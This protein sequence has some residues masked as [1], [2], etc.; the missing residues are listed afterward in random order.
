MLLPQQMHHRKPRGMESFKPLRPAIGEPVP[1]AILGPNVILVAG[2]RPNPSL[3]PA[4]VGASAD[5]GCLG[6]VAETAAAAPHACATLASAPTAAAPDAVATE[7]LGGVATAELSAAPALSASCLRADPLA[8]GEG[9][10]G[11]PSSSTCAA[12]GSPEEALGS[13]ATSSCGSG[14]CSAE[15]AERPAV[16]ITGS[17]RDGSLLSTFATTRRKQAAKYSHNLGDSNR[18]ANEPNPCVTKT[19]QLSLRKGR[20]TKQTSLMVSK[21]LGKQTCSTSRKPMLVRLPPK[22]NCN[23]VTP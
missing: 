22:S 4:S 6:G 1:A 2:P 7:P 9:A 20:T 14:G 11:R 15:A 10:H 19:Q 8:H 3:G 12:R 18:Q 17:T 13:P 16:A 21:S 23:V 5:A